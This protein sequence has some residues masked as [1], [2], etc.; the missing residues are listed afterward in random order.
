DRSTQVAV[1]HEALQDAMYPVLT[2]LRQESFVL[3]LFVT[4]LGRNGSMMCERYD[5][6]AT[7]LD[8]IFEHGISRT[9]SFHPQCIC[10]SWTRGMRPD[11]CS[12]SA[13]VDR[14]RM[15][16]AYDHRLRLEG[17]SGSTKIQVRVGPSRIAEDR[18]ENVG[19]MQRVACYIWEQRGVK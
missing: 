11:T 1:R 16:P 14:T 7:D 10:S 9:R 19:A 15:T 17:G 18:R 12:I 4:C 3:L 5:I 8:C 13:R 2:R 6:E